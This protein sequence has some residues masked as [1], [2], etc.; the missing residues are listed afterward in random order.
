MSRAA[1]YSGPALDDNRRARGAQCLW[2]LAL[3]FCLS[4]D[5]QQ[6]LAGRTSRVAID[7]L[8]RS[9]AVPQAPRRIVSLAPSV[10]DSLFALGLGDRVVGVSDFC[11]LPPGKGPIARVGG[12]LNPSLEA[13]RALQPDLLVGTTS[14]NDP[15]L[16]SQSAALGLPL[17]TLHTPDVER[18]LSAI[19]SLAEALGEPSRGRA[20]AAGLRQ[21][22]EVVRSRVAGRPQ[23]RVLFIVWGQPLVVPGRAS[24][25]TDALQH[26]GGISVS[27]AA[28]AAWPAFDLESAIR[29][30]PDVILSTARNRDIVDRLRSEPAWRGVP[31][32]RHDRMHIVSEAIEQPGPSLVGGIEEVAHILHPGAFG[33][34][35]ER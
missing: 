32:V 34:G 20:L 10:T 7:G 22:L 30:A 17:Y 4:I 15:A 5:C 18:T 35:G 21:R 1:P 12:M 16:A 33:A 11:R 23:P 13:I 27:A 8:G 9:V 26:A 29:T 6:G 28:A 25:L 31:A 2:M 3:L 24:F 19:E 14:G